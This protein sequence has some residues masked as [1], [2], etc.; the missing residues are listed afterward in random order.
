MPAFKYQTVSGSSGA[1]VVD[2]PDRSSALRTL[3]QRGITPI[4]IEVVRG[5]S[6]A[7]SVEPTSESPNGA[8]APPRTHVR[9]T[10]IG[11]GV[12]MSRGEIAGLIREIATALQAG[13]TLPQA[14]R[15][16]A[17]QGRSERQRVMIQFLLDQIEHGKPLSEA[18]LAWGK[19]FTELLVS[20][21]RA[22][23]ASGKL[24]EV[25]AQ[26]ADLMERDV[27]LRRA[28]LGATIYPML[29][30]GLV[31]IATI[32]L[33]TV[34]IPRLIAPLAGQI[35]HTQLPLPTRIV[36]GV[37]EFIGAWWWLLL[38]GLVVGV[39]VFRRLYSQ[40]GPRLAI[41]RALLRIPALGPLL[42][43]AAVARF[44]RTLGTLVSAGLPALSALRATRPTLGNRAMEHA[45]EN[46]CEQVAAGKTIS[47][48][49]E[50][51][52]VF[53]PLLVQIVGVGER[54]GRLAE[55][56]RRAAD[57]L[58]SRTQAS[59]KLFTAVLPPVLIMIFAGIAGFVI[60]AILLV[61]LKIQEMIG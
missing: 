50:A 56:L 2:A 42:R 26:A 34:I 16:S 21:I 3:R 29:L 53:P 52:G 7:A 33:V 45:V 51:S 55:L 24:D 32:V 40:P 22:G 12:A 39:M 37:A 10:G 23:E 18:A 54:S 48:P 38:A 58:E 4:K 1:G 19:P 35:K 9:A 6:L 27:A 13:L 44:T 61:V 20:L 47:E 49:L 15:T 43:D 41:D 59:L 8:A 31:T 57:A 11:G 17:K 14:L 36:M 5:G 28:V 60:A 30:A 25:L 46:V